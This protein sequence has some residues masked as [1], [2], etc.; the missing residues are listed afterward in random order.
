MSIDMQFK[1]SHEIEE[2]EVLCRLREDEF[3]FTY[4]PSIY[5]NAGGKCDP[6]VQQAIDTINNQYWTPWITTI[7]LYN[8]NYEL[9]AIGKLANPISKRN[10]V[11]M[12]FIIRFDI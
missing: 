8:D 4:N 11:D 2:V 7:G 5:Q 12:N 3:T 10:D 6:Y 9:I 1:G